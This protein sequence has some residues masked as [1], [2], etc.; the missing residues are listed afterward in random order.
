MARFQSDFLSGRPLGDARISLLA[1]PQPSAN[2]PRSGAV[3]RHP[4]PAHG[5]PERVGLS[6][7]SC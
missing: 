7:S 2:P 4:H 5:G 3:K 1:T 6:M